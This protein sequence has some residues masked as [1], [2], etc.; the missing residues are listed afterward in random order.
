MLEPVPR[1]VDVRISEAVRSGEIDHDATSGRGD[2]RGFL[3]VEAEK[4]DVGAT[5]QRC[6]VR[7]EARDSAPPVTAEPRVE[8]VRGLPGERVRAER[9]ELE[10]RMGEY[11]VQRFLARVARGT[12]GGCGR[13]EDYYALVLH[14][15]RIVSSESR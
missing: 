5:R 7:D 10:A 15:M 4:D 12:D 13:N 1:L 6:V 2:R 3:V 8:R 14:D 11:A 9:I